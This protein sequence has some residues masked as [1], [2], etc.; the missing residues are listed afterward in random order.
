MIAMS[1]SGSS[2]STSDDSSVSPSEERERGPDNEFTV[3]PPVPRITP[4]SSLLPVHNA[5]LPSSNNVN[6]S[7]NVPSTPVAT[8]TCL[9]MSSGAVHSSDILIPMIVH[10][11]Y[12]PGF[13]PP[14]CGKIKS[15]KPSSV[16]AA[17]S[18]ASV[19]HGKCAAHTLPDSQAVT[20][21]HERDVPVNGVMLM[22][23]PD[24][25]NTSVTSSAP[26]G[27]TSPTSTLLHSTAAGEFMPG[28]LV[29]SRISDPD[30]STNIVSVT[31][32]P[33]SNQSAN[34]NVAAEADAA[35]IA[36]VA[37]TQNIL[38]AITDDRNPIIAISTF[39]MDVSDRRQIAGH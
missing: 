33:A 25:F 14:V 35:P 17:Y 38:V 5:N 24:K 8:F 39:H 23:V 13:P 1:N 20:N 2:F 22:A 27:P 21:A 10:S 11:T 30:V 28:A 15:A 29:F 6:A 26:L 18:S 32:A 31:F 9:E 19:N 4:V 3:I 7:E 37:I 34:L 12:Q 36:L 16:P